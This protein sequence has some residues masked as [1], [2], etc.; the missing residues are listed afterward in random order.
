[1]NGTEVKQYLGPKSSAARE[2]KILELVR[3]GHYLIHWVPIHVDAGGRRATLY[4][5]G[6]ALRL[7]DKADSFRPGMTQSTQQQIADELNAVLVTPKLSDE[8]Y[9]QAAIQPMECLDFGGPKMADTETMIKH[10]ACVDARIRKLMDELYGGEVDASELLF[11]PVGKDWVNS[12]R[13]LGQP[14]VHGAPAGINYGAQRQ[15]VAPNPKTG[16]FPSAT[17]YPPVVVRQPE[18]RAHPYNHCDYSQVGRFALRLVQ[19][20]EPAGL[21]GLGQAHC[22]AGAS[23]R[24]PDGSEGISR[25][26]DIYDA[27]QDEQLWPLIN[28]SGPVYMRHFAVPWQK[29]QGL[30]AGQGIWQGF[31]V[32]PPP[33]NRLEGEEPPPGPPVEVP[34]TQ[35]AGTS[36]WGRVGVFAGSLAAGW[37]GL[38][39]LRGRR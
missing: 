8:I 1:M 9:R 3:A 4:V 21:S 28:H 39:W 2:K 36:V 20:C 18:G 7:G 15:D 16:P 22:E 26:V 11:A 25:C 14:Q 13:L 29:P 34:P 30:G 35:I 32:T 17:L 24:L 19:V 6:D 5:S 31:P 37:F 38:K 12:R 10:S 27:A 33:P 23:C